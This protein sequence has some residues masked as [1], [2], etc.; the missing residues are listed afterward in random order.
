M[1]RHRRAGWLFGAFS[2]VA[3]GGWLVRRGS[4]RAHTSGVAGLI[5][6]GDP[7]R[8]APV[9]RTH[10]A[11]ADVDPVLLMA[12]LYNESYKPH[13]PLLE[14]AWQAFR[15]DSSFGVANMHRRTFEQVR[16]ER[17]F[18]ERAWQEL[19]DDPDLAIQAAAWHL[20]DL[21]TRLPRIAGGA[22]TTAE[23]LAMGYNAGAR[24]ML[25]FAGGRQPG[26][27]ARAYVDRLH[28]HW[29]RAAKA[30]QQG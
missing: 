19:P 18:A 25:R 22:F 14:R 1:G 24:N 23:L 8:L 13:N 29:E 20:H 27:R 7:S 5:P 6:G 17:P 28:E 4:A 12:I 9:V 16:F 15:R 21:R 3:L 26:P 30:L 11:E 2:A 10:A